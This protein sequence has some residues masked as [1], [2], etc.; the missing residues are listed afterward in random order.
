MLSCYY[1]HLVGIDCPGCGMQRACIEI[2]KGNLRESIHTYPALIPIF[3]TFFL[4]SIHLVF[5]L[6]NGADFVKYSFILS[7][8]VI[9]TNY[10]LRIF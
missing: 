4:L 10:V 8:T 5:K 3:T 9:F 6:K 1:K 7:A 2:L